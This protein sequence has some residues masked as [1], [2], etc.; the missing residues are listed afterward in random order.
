METDAMVTVTI[1]TVV[2][3]TV[4]NSILQQ[5]VVKDHSWP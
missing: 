2:M 4:T 3:D 1:A 5:C